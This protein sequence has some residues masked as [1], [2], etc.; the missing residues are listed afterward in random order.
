MSRDAMELIKEESLRARSKS[1]QHPS[2]RPNSDELLT[3]EGESSS[4]EMS[5]V[6]GPLNETKEESDRRGLSYEVVDNMSNTDCERSVLNVPNEPE[7][8]M[9]LPNLSGS[10][11]KKDEE[12][13]RYLSDPASTS[14]GGSSQNGTNLISDTI[15][16]KSQP[17]PSN[18]NREAKLVFANEIITRLS[19]DK[20]LF[21]CVLEGMRTKWLAKRG[22]ETNPTNIGADVGIADSGSTGSLACEKRKASFQ[23]KLPEDFTSLIPPHP[24]DL[25]KE[26]TEEENSKEMEPTRAAE[27]EQ[28]N[29][30]LKEQPA[31][32]EAISKE[33]ESVPKDSKS[34]F[35]SDENTLSS[36]DKQET[37]DLES[38]REAV[39]QSGNEKSQL[40]VSTSYGPLPR[41][42]PC[43]NCPCYVTDYV[44]SIK[45]V[46]ELNNLTWLVQER[47]QV[48]F[49][50]DPRHSNALNPSVVGAPVPPTFDQHL[51][52]PNVGYLHSSQLSVFAFQCSCL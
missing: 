43:F 21:F 27:A 10:N 48:L 12:V 31:K 17:T 3:S 46:D 26:S 33:S 6:S 9:V 18:G 29:E 30:E 23:L 38:I 34:S 19:E 25:F 45:S 7:W 14:L 42:P 50:A 8:L 28:A 40:R 47:R 22:S 20:E 24:A 2:N 13:I 4:S 52:H 11:Q 49:S 5:V 51:E 15:S 41:H 1:C 36:V 39:P 35:K 16:Q 37:E 44:N 32:N